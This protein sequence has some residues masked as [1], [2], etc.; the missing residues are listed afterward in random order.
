MIQQSDRA[1]HMAQ[2]SFEKIPEAFQQGLQSTREAIEE[3]PATAVF[4]AFG[5]GLGVGVGL[6]VL[7]G[8]SSVFSPPKR[9]RYW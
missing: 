2:E 8:A 5:I 7:M 6:A 1:L 3:Y 9:P 4:A